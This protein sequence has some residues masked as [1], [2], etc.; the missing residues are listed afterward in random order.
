MQRAR[1]AVI[2]LQI[3]AI[4]L[5]A[6]ISPEEY[7]KMQRAAPEVVYIEVSSV[8]I[9]RHLGK[10]SGCAFYDFELRRDAVVDAKVLQVIRSSSGL[11][12]GASIKIEY[13]SIKRCWGWNGPR[14][15]E[16][17]EPKARVYAYL[18]RQGTGTFVPAARGAS[19]SIE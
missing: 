9:H 15:I 18:V 7:R 4:A 16:L 11:R 17:L 13:S 8:A 5:F 19:F 2:V 10:E 6:D 3:A 14:S 12:A 1:V